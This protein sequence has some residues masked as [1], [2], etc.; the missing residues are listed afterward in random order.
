[1]AT[2]L[3]QP[4]PSRLFFVVH[5]RTEILKNKF[6][7]NYKK[8]KYPTG[9]LLYFTRT[10]MSRCK[11]FKEVLGKCAKQWIA[12]PA[13]VVI[14]MSFIYNVCPLLYCDATP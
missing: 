7:H 1:V 8:G 9:C 2:T 14:H 10:S 4:E 5:H 12:L 3:P 6:T 11:L 13:S